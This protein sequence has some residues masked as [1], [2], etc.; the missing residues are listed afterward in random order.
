M[1][2]KFDLPHQHVCCVKLFIFCCEEITFLL[3]ISDG[4]LCHLY[5]GYLTK[6]KLSC[7]PAIKILAQ[8][9]DKIRL[10]DTQLTAVHADL[11]QLSL[12]AKIFNPALKLLDVDVTAIASTEVSVLINFFVEYKKN[13]LFLRMVIMMPN[14]FYFIIIMEE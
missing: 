6:H 10:F 7:I 2:N 12:C 13:T 9:V 4:E 3:Y 8:A 14:I 11:C 5:T 1:E